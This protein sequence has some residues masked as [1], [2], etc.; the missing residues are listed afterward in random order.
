MG[1]KSV[2]AKTSQGKARSREATSNVDD[3]TLKA[4][5]TDVDGGDSALHART[6]TSKEPLV[7]VYRSLST[8]ADVE[9]RLNHE[10]PAPDIKVYRR[11]VAGSSA[12]KSGLSTQTLPRH[13]GRSTPVDGRDRTS[14]VQSFNGTMPVRMRQDGNRKSMVELINESRQGLSRMSTADST[15]SIG[16]KG[17]K[18][19]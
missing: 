5:Q 12:M 19:G 11:S 17:R 2:K 14:M 1:N 16:P 15:S 9:R 3:I 4:P 10:E 6:E 13:S 18:Y 7:K 8:A